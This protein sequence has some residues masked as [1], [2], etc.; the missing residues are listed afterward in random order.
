M[1]HGGQMPS[2]RRELEESLL[3]VYMQIYIAEDI[4]VQFFWRDLQVFAADSVIAAA[5]SEAN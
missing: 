1:G 3:P 2:P 5:F 4:L